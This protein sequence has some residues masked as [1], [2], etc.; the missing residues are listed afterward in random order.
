MDNQAL[1]LRP[2]SSQNNTAAE[3]APSTSRG[4]AHMIFHQGQGLILEDEQLQPSASAVK[5]EQES[6]ESE[7]PL[8]QS[9]F[10]AFR[11]FLAEKVVRQDT[12]SDLQALEVS[13]PDFWPTIIVRCRQEWSDLDHMPGI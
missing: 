1:L 7:M 9:M 6:R 13:S 8:R 12:G 4:S 11:K 5:A 3:S 2:A 10:G